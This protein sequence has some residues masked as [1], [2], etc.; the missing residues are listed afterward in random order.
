MCIYAYKHMCPN[1]WH[2]QTIKHSGYC[3]LIAMVTKINKLVHNFPVFPADELPAFIL[4]QEARES[5]TSD[6]EC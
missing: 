2:N 6:V 3:R 1:R 4:E 5:D